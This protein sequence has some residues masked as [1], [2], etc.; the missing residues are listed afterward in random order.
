MNSK[1]QILSMTMIAIGGTL[2][3]IRTKTF[4]FYPGMK[5]EP[6]KIYEHILFH[7]GLMVFAITLLIDFVNMA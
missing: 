6:Y 3:C 2:Y 5:K 4:L 7:G 1:I